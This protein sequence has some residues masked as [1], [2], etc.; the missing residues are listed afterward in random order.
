MHVAY[1]EIKM[2]NAQYRY[3]V[4]C[5]KRLSRARM[6]QNIVS[7][8]YMATQTLFR[9]S[10]AV[11]TF[12]C[13]HI[14]NKTPEGCKFEENVCNLNKVNF[15]HMHNVATEFN[16]CSLSKRDSWDTGLV[17]GASLHCICFVKYK[18]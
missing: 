6:C 4:E 15:N 1:N 11:T 9:L 14:L 7:N 2:K 12:S 18:I 3:N 8:N 17:E 5:F 10:L 13:I 16:L